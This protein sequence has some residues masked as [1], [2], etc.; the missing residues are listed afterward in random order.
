MIELVAPFLIPSMIMSFT[1]IMTLSK[2]SWAA[3]ALVDRVHLDLAE[4]LVELA[5]HLL[6]G[7]LATLDHALRVHAELLHLPQQRRRLAVVLKRLVR[8]LERL[9]LGALADEAAELDG[10]VLQHGVGEL[11]MDRELRKPR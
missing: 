2:F 6:G 5:L 7:L 9:V 1:F 3:G 4:Q 10:F 11:G 8:A